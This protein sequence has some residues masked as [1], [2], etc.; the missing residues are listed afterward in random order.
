MPMLTATTV[1]QVRQAVKQA[2]ADGLRIGLVPTMG[3]LHEGHLSLIRAARLDCPY[4][5]VSIFVNP[6]QFVAGD[7]YQ[8][9]PRTPETDLDACRTE[10]VD[11]VFAPNAEQMYHHQPLTTVQVAKL[12]ETLCGAHRPGHFDG[13]TTVVAKLFNIVQPDAA[14]FGQKDAQQVVVIEK[15]AADLFF[16]VQIVVCPTVRGPDGLALSSRNDY[17]SDQQRKQATSLSTAL[18]SAA[19]QIAQGQRSADTLIEL[20]RTQ[21]TAAGPCRIDYISI[22]HPETLEPIEQITGPVLLAAAVRIGQARLIDN[23]L[24]A[25]SLVRPV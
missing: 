6:T 21:I 11:L 1:D 9:Y 10:N 4:I 14:Y 19:D 16:P 3:H 18:Q 15:M 2:R 5:V 25:P 17:L 13:V 22:A 8:T 12:A 24:A 7:D 23:I 20:M